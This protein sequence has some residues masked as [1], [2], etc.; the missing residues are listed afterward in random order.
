MRIW[1]LL[2]SLVL[3]ICVAANAGAQPAAYPSSPIRLMVPFAPGGPVDAIGRLLAQKLTV[4]LGQSV[5]VENRGGAGGGI[6]AQAVASSDPAGY[7]LL[8]GSTATISILPLVNANVHYDADRDFVPIGVVATGVQ[9]VVAS[10]H[11]PVSNLR[12]FVSYA[13]GRSK[14]VTAATGGSATPFF[15]AMLENDTRLKFLQI[16]Y[17]GTGPGLTDLAAGHVDISVADTSV[18][19]PMVKA[20]QIKALGIASLE[21]NPLAPELPTIA[22]QGYPGFEAGGWFGVFAPAGIPDSVFRRLSSAL[23]KLSADAGLNAQLQQL[24]LTPSWIIGHAAVERVRKENAKFAA[25][26]K[27]MNITPE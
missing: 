21:R 1:N 27:G 3:G 4:E 15:I 12:E 6:G 18:V 5:Y 20:G 16:P 19:F 10:N 9:V 24:G 26:A 23:T 17:K 22:E 7:S 14:P 13:K 8:L 25:L 2:S 11:V